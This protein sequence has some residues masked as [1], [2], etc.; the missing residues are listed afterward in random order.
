MYRVY[1]VD[2]SEVETE[3]NSDIARSLGDIGTVYKNKGN[4]DEA[5]MYY[6]KSLKIKYR[7][8]GVDES[9]VETEGNSHIAS[10]LHSIGIVYREK[11]NY[12]EALM[13]YQKSLK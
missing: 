10:S 13:Y 3:G 9:E 2:E 6:Q 1:G 5:L 12:D 8:Y 7:V 4:Y 11:G